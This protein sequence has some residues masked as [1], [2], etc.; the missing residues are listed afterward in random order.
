MT[1]LTGGLVTGTSKKERIGYF[2]GIPW[3]WISIT[4]TVPTNTSVLIN[5]GI[6]PY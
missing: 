2:T 4:V 5:M 6:N 3:V 1:E